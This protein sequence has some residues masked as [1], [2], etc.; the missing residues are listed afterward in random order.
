MHSAWNAL[1]LKEVMMGAFTINLDKLW[2]LQGDDNRTD[3]TNS[4]HVIKAKASEPLLCSRH[5]ATCVYNINTV[6]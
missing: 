5:F 1:W 3:H 6:R 4:Y 2:F